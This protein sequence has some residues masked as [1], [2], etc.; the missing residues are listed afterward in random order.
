MG[1]TE[2]I[3]VFETESPFNPNINDRVV[4]CTETEEKKRY[5]GK[6]TNISSDGDKTFHDIKPIEGMEDRFPNINPKVVRV[7]RG[8]IICKLNPPN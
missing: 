8:F 1:V 5:L 3:D 2:I 6:I 7:T 4:F